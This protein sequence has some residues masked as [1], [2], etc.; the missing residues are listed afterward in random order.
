MVFSKSFTVE[1]FF[2]DVGDVFN[3]EN[4]LQHLKIEKLDTSILVTDVGDEMCW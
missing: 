4:G 3:V 2:Q 1:T